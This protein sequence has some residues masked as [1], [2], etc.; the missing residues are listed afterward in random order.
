MKPSF[1]KRSLV[2]FYRKFLVMNKIML[3]LIL[4]IV[5]ASCSASEQTTI[6]NGNNTNT[7]NGWQKV[8]VFDDISEIDTIANYSSS[9]VVEEAN[10][11]VQD[12]IEKLTVLKEPVS[13]AIQ[14]A[15]QLGAFSSEQN[16]KRFVQSNQFKLGL[17][18]NI[19][20]NEKVKLF[21]VRTNSFTNR[22]EA[23]KMRNKLKL[24]NSFNNAFI[25]VE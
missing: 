6:N 19:S 11:E 16:A 21:V 4:G 12:S 8:Y 3:A 13:S 18:L 1:F 24:K 23:E 7:V 14:Y 9:T 17:P 2:R 5:L 22:I 25:V 15:V 10:Q 20:W